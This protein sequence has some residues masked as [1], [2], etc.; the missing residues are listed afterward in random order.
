MLVML[1]MLVLLVMLVML[2]VVG[3]GCTCRCSACGGL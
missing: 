2:V 1:V 3:G